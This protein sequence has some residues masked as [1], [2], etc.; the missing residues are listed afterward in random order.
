MLIQFSVQNYKSIKDEQTFSMSASKGKELPNNYF[1][2]EAL[3]VDTLLRSA[4]IY[5]AN[6]AGKSNL[7]EALMVMKEIVLDSSS[8][9]QEGELLPVTPYLLGDSVES[10]TE[11]EVI[12]VSEGVKYQYG[13][14][15]SEECVLE[16]W[17]FAFPHGKAQR[18]FERSFDESGHQGYYFG[19]SLTGQKDTWSKATRKNALFLSTA[20]Q[21]NSD[22]LKPVYNWFKKTLRVSTRG[23]WGSSYSGHLCEN[24]ETKVDVLKF[25]ES[26][27][28][29]IVDVKI[30]KSSENI[31]PDKFTEMLKDDVREKFLSK[32]NKK[33]KTVHKNT[34]GELIDFDFF[35]E[36]DGT[37][38][39]F[40]LS[41]PWIDSLKNG[42]VLVIDELHD[43]L[44]PL[45]VK[46]LVEIFH[47]SD[48][49]IKN[50]QLVFTTHETSILNQDV[51][52]RDQ[53]W[54]CQK[55]SM[56]STDVV[57]LAEFSPRKGRDNLEA[58]YLGGRYGALPIL[59]EFNMGV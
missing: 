17:L 25:L 45:M 48:V 56:H 23:T 29:G 8:S 13:F 22:K 1:E 38:K 41:G 32:K 39:I 49:N 15:V 58:S 42:Y 6:A 11:F 51:F 12:F 33:I 59:K 26:A 54:F 36:S 57:S 18:W 55:T 30:E 19:S 50:A 31:L 28:L 24:E 10:G 20:V 53:V 5:G 44:H 21:L 3:G 14:I 27:N 34:R 4:A 46:F 52:R 37:K 2:T 35:D 40:N 16:E 7:L 43:A 47:D 9:S